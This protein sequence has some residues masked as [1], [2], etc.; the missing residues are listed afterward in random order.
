MSHVS[1]DTVKGH[2]GFR[3]PPRTGWER[4]GIQIGLLNRAGD[5]PAP[6]RYVPFLNLH[7]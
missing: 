5:N 2:R 1:E 6:F 3:G 7:F 4:Q